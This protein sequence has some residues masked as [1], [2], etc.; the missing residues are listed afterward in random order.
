M[1]TMIVMVMFIMEVMMN[2]DDM[3]VMFI[4]EESQWIM[5][6]CLVMAPEQ[7]FKLKPDP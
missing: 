6:A 3:I 4:D 7:L 2:D 5:M 1:M